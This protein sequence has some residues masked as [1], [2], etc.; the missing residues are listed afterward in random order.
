MAI[1]PIHKHLSEIHKIGSRTYQQLIAPKSCALLERHGI[2]GAG[3]SFAK[4]G[5][6]WVRLAPAMDVVMVCFEGAG[7]ALCE[8]AWKRFGYGSAY[9]MPARQLHA[10][11]AVT[12]K[13]WGVA[14]VIYAP[15]RDGR[16]TLSDGPPALIECDPRPLRD[17]LGGLYREI[18]AGADAPLLHH[19]VELVH[20]YAMLLAAPANLDGRMW[21]LWQ[22]LDADLARPWTLAEMA[23]LCAMSPETLRRLCHRQYRRSP[24]EQLTL[25][26]MQRANALLVTT[27]AKI[28]AVANAVGY[29]NLFTFSAAFKRVTGTP[30]SQFRKLHR[31]S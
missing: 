18:T 25:L 22:A 12:Q 29:G 15:R 11:Q 24:V 19:W 13:T 2:L 17:S 31:L 5:F 26:R 21:R 16:S 30:P 28:E 3:L 7:S 10:Y 20:R 4:P 23:R 8:G 27:D 1:G 6:E 14:W 9:L